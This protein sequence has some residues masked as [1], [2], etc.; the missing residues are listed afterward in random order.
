VEANVVATKARYP[1]VKTLCEPQ[2]QFLR[3]EVKLFPHIIKHHAMKTY[4]GGGIAPPF[5]TSV[6]DENWPASR[7][8]H[9]TSGEL[10]PG[11]HCIGGWVSGRGGLE[12]YALAKIK[13]TLP[14]SETAAVT[15]PAAYILY[16]LLTLNKRN[17]Q[18]SFHYKLTRIPAYI[19][20]V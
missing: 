4:G 10:V 15:Q 3:G 16:R 1:V 2:T 12:V 11:T 13:K 7:A 9:F 14:L 8:G 17:A 20:K 6:L 18:C 5:L 19:Y